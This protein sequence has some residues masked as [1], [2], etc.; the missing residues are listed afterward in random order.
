MT[1]PMY[2]PMSFSNDYTFN[3]GAM[4]CTPDCAWAVF[5]AITKE[6]TCA[7][8]YQAVRDDCHYINWR[9]VKDDDE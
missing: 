9:S 3:H 8:A 2:C 6:Y 4:E 5:N 1:K 7:M